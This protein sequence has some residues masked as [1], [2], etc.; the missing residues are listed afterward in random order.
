MGPHKRSFL[1][2]HTF[3]L[4]LKELPQEKKKLPQINTRENMSLRSLSLTYFMT[5]DNFENISVTQFPHVTN[6]D[7]NSTCN[8]DS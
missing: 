6:V 3:N 7:D 5:T 1:E 4:D 8:R 2:E